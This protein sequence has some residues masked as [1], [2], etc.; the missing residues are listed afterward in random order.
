MDFTI[1]RSDGKVVGVEVNA[2]KTLRPRKTLGGCHCL[3]IMNARIFVL[4]YYYF[5]FKNK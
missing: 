2:V 1:E 5:S 4:Y 3:L